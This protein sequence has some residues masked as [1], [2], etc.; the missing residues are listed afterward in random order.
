M[1][2]DQTLGNAPTSTTFRGAVNIDGV[3][4][5]TSSNGN[6]KTGGISTQHWEGTQA[7]MMYGAQQ[8]ETLGYEYELKGGATWTLDVTYPVDII[9][10]GINSQPVPIAI[11]ELSYQQIEQSLYNAKDRIFIG[12]LSPQD[13]RNI[14]AK[15]RNP[16]NTSLTPYDLETNDDIGTVTYNLKQ[17][18]VEGRVLFIPILK[19]TIIVSNNYDI[20]TIPPIGNWSDKNAG[21]VM[22]TSELLNL[23]NNAPNPLSNLSA[24]DVTQLTQN[25]T[26]LNVGRYDVNGNYFNTPVMGPVFDCESLINSYVGWLQYPIE[27]QTL[28]VHKKQYSQQWIFNQWSFGTFGLYDSIDNNAGEKIPDVSLIPF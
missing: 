28:S 16:T 3:K 26:T 14:D 20:S 27:N 22:L 15:L 19:R 25:H 13:I 6:A 5:I 4:G 18:G 1:T 2:L 12:K 17:A 11:W 24:T 10:H 8:A 23:Y 9:L 21:K 7:Q